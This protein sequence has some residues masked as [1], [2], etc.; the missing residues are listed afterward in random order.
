MFAWD[1][2]TTDILNNKK[3]AGASNL[4]EKKHRMVCYFFEK[5]FDLMMGLDDNL[6]SNPGFESFAGNWNRAKDA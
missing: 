1:E 2:R 5:L 3:V 6:S 4:N